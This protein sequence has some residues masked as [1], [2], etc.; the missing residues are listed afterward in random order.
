MNI[1]VLASGNGTNFEAVVRSAEKGKLRNAKIKILISDKEESFV[2]KRAKKHN[3]KSVFVDP[4]GFSSRT[5]FDKEVVRILRKEKIR[6]V[7]LAGFMRILSPYFVKA[8]KNRILN[9]HP[10]LLPSFKGESAI[11]K[12]YKY[13]VKV[14]GVTV[15]FVDNDVDHGPIIFQEALKIKEGESPESLEKRIHRLEHKLYPEAI[16]LFIQGRLK[17]RG[18][19]VAII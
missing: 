1:A 12:A 14:T 10:A 8:F 3:I 17:V 18:R 16:K 4:K 15:H 7:V 11:K 19:K 5:L 6:L 13:G 2:Q 9:I